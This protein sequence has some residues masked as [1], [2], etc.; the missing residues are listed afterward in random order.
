MASRTSYVAAESSKCMNPQRESQKDAT[1]I[2]DLALEGTEYLL[3]H[4]I[5]FYLLE[6]S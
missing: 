1:T 4:P 5:S 6:T 2:Y 3:P